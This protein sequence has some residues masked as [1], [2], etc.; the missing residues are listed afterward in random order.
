MKAVGLANLL[1]SQGRLRTPRVGATDPSGRLAHLLGVYFP[2]KAQASRSSAGHSREGDSDPDV[3]DQFFKS[4]TQGG[5]GAVSSAS[6]HPRESVWASPTFSPPLLLAT[7]VSR[8][9]TACLAFT[10]QG[11][12][13]LWLKGHCHPSPLSPSDQLSRPQVPKTVVVL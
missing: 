8:E 2:R 1:L 7:A 4:T 10:S 12:P 5:T 11:V 9:H 6:S 13:L 3:L